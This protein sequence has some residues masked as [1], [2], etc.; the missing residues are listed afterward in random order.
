[1][2][3]TLKAKCNKETFLK[4]TQNSYDCYFNTDYTY[5]WYNRKY[6]AEIDRYRLLTATPKI[7]S[8]ILRGLK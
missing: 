7:T 4:Y 6:D 1:M 8:E 3:T 5:G 2:K